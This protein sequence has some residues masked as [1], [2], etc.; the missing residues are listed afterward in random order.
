MAKVVKFYSSAQ[1]QIPVLTFSNL[2]EEWGASQDEAPPAWNLAFGMTQHGKLSYDGIYWIY[3]ANVRPTTVTG[4]YAPFLPIFHAAVVFLHR[5][6]VHHVLLI[7]ED[8][9]LKQLRSDF[10]PRKIPLSESETL[11][12]Y[13]DDLRQEEIYGGQSP[14]CLASPYENWP[15]YVLPGWMSAEDRD[16]TMELVQSAQAEIT[17]RNINAQVS[18][19]VDYRLHVP[20]LKIVLRHVAA[21]INPEHR[22]INLIQ[23]DKILS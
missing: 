20:G 11:D 2:N 18:S 4:E 14:E 10:D 23:Q 21:C 8:L 7:R 13:W 9:Q 22:Q 12:D 1:H 3:E 19:A 6:E 5:D 16:S 15:C 17:R